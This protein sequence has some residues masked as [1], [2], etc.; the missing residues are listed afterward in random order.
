[1][2]KRIKKAVIDKM[3]ATYGGRFQIVNFFE[4]GGAAA[5]YVAELT[6]DSCNNKTVAASFSKMLFGSTLQN[7]KDNY[8]Q[9]MRSL[10]IMNGFDTLVQPLLSEE[11][12]LLFSSGSEQST[13]S[14]SFSTPIETI[15]AEF[16]QYDEFF[17]VSKASLS[18]VVVESL[19]QELEKSGYEFTVHISGLVNQ[20]LFEDITEDYFEHNDPPDTG[21]QFYS[22]Y[23]DE[24]RYVLAES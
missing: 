3:E 8:I 6:G 9:C 22:L 24:G 13:G 17:I 2:S 23:F 14:Y 16:D 7:M 11:Y 20:A 1:M 15:L 21:K 19:M 4:I 5:N 18:V 10:E 12:K